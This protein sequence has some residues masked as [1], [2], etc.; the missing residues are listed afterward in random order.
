MVE[1]LKILQAQRVERDSSHPS[2]HLEEIFRNS[3]SLSLSLYFSLRTLQRSNVNV[4]IS[5]T[6]KASDLWKLIEILNRAVLNK[7]TLFESICPSRTLNSQTQMTDASPTPQHHHQ[8]TH[9]PPMQSHL[10]G[11][12]GFWFP[13]SVGIAFLLTVRPPKKSGQ[14]KRSHHLN[15]LTCWCDIQ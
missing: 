2:S 9:I 10:L 7:H 14:K 15:C 8:H 1:E 3:L 11:D 13:M 4:S 6:Q 5:E 12:V